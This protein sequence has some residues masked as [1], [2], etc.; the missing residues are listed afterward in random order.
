M[1]HSFALILISVYQ[2]LQLQTNIIIIHSGPVADVVLPSHNLTFSSS[3]GSTPSLTMK[4]HFGKQL[5]YTRTETDV[6]EHEV[7]VRTGD[8]NLVKRASGKCSK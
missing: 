4:K 5:S 1:L 6:F 8:I 7:P 2:L 3:S